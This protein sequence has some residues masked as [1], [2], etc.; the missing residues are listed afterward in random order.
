[1]SLKEM[2]FKRKSVRS[3]VNASIGPNSIARIEKFI[4]GIKPLYPDIKVR[5]EIVDRESVKCICPWT[6]KQ[7]VAIFTEDKPGALINVG[8]M[9]QQLDLYLADIGLGACWLGMAQWEG[10]KEREDGLKFVMTMAFGKPKG[11]GQRDDVL[12]FKRKNMTEISDIQDARLV[13]ARL[14]PS[15]ANSQP[16]Y[17]THEDDVIH[18]YCAHKGLLNKSLGSTNQMDVGIA[19]AHMYVANEE[20]FEFFVVENPV[21]VKDHTYMGS[22][23]I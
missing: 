22:F 12:K 4:N 3:F 13:P 2:I 9:F 5:A 17:F 1:M 16:W 7:V 14:A 18:V 15:S 6:T 21:P 10:E 11:E 23:R 20:T 19:L 8:F